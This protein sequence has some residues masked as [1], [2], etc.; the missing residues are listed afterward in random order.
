MLFPRF[1]SEDLKRPYEPPTAPQ[2]NRGNGRFRETELAAMADMDL[3]EIEE[4]K[5]LDGLELAVEAAAG[6]YATL[7]TANLRLGSQ[8]LMSVHGNMWAAIHH[9]SQAIDA[10]NSELANIRRELEALRIRKPELENQRWATERTRPYACSSW[11]RVRWQTQ[12]KK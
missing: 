11:M 10:R 1:Q 7:L 6:S 2:P 9:A 12:T 8:V 3:P 5:T 4:L